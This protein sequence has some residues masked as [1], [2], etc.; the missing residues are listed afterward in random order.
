[1]DDV[2][3]KVRFAAKQAGVVATAG[4]DLGLQLLH[5]DASLR[6]YVRIETGDGRKSV[7]AMVPA[8]GGARFS[9][10]S[11]L[12]SAGRRAGTQT[13]FVDVQQYLYQL[14]IRVPSIEHICESNGVL[15]LEDL[16]D[17]TFEQ[18][19]LRAD[20][21]ELLGMY[22]DA[23]ELLVRLQARAEHA[24]DKN[25]VAYTR[26]YEQD[27][28]QW[29]LE[30]FY[31]NLVQPCESVLHPEE[32][33]LVHQAF[34]DLARRMSTYP[35]GFVHRDFQSRNLMLK[36]GELVL[37]DFQDA[38][39]GPAGYDLVALLRDSYVVLEQ[40]QVQY[41]VDRYLD[42]CKQH[43]LLR[44]D[45][46][47]FWDQFHRLTLLRKLKDAGR[48]VYFQR[49]RQDPGYLQYV[50]VSLRYASSAFDRLEDLQ[51]CRKVLAKVVPELA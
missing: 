43:K 44:P 50:P 35:R 29:E 23:V 30:H 5:G 13:P 3:E 25:C 22:G 12:P 9:S 48:F 31:E 6:R 20:A 14:G 26:P 42:G 33:H 41:L 2:N 24:P 28:M 46:D 21:D 47:V 38:L 39:Y 51:T 7:V 40:E 36:S 34:R 37:I 4:K 17:E 1:M 16:G 45:P 32:M 8:P 11:A 15:I 10:R 19:A 18:A 49:T 27:L